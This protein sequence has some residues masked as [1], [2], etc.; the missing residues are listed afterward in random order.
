MS[1]PCGTTSYASLNSTC[2]HSICSL[3]FPRLSSY[4]PLY[5]PHHH[6]PHHLYGCATCHHM[7]MPCFTLAVVTHVT[8]LLVHLSY[9]HHHLYAQLTYHMSPTESSMLVLTVP[10]MSF[11]WS[12]SLYSQV[13]CG[14][15]RTIQS[16]FFL[17]VWKKKQIAIT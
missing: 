15:V 3:V 5:L 12:Y 9:P 16:S 8:S 10:A 4:Q 13:P 17:L 14:T 7:N 6:I 11:L 2:H 1:R